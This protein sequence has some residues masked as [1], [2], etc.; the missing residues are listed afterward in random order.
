MCPHGANFTNGTVTP[1]PLLL[2]FPLFGFGG[3]GRLYYGRGASEDHQIGYPYESSRAKAHR[4]T[5]NDCII[6]AKTPARANHDGR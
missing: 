4:I 1:Y 6:K 3:L 2:T 5:Y